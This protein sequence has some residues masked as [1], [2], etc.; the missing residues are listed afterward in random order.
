MPAPIRIIVAACA[1]VALLIPAAAQARVAPAIDWSPTTSVGTYDYGAV[2]PGQTA[3]LTFTL[4]NSG[5]SATAMLTVVLSGS[6][7]FSMT[8]DACTGTSLGPNKSCEVTVQYAPLTAGQSDSATL[9]ASGKKVAASASITLTGNDA[10]TGAPDLSLSPGT[11]TGSSASGTKNFSYDFGAVAGGTQ[12]FTVTN[13]GTGASGTLNLVGCCAAG[14]VLEND[15]C[16]GIDLAASGACS[17]DL[18][19]TALEGCS[20]ADAFLTFV[21]VLD[22]DNNTNDIALVGMGECP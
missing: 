14:F 16:T 7:A 21:V 4:T 22:V 10:S 13:E 19:F 18:V 20:S 6:S 1:A 2:T 17:F 11:Y 5:G 3:S 9:E 8:S 15:T 12:T